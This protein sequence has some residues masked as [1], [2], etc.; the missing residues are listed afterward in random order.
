[1]P[2]N[3]LNYVNLNGSL[4]ALYRNDEFKDVVI[5][6]YIDKSNHSEACISFNDPKARIFFSY[7]PD[8]DRKKLWDY[9]MIGDTI[10]KIK[11]T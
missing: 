4:P 11:K 8:G 2:Y 9:V 7:R 1:V 10:R 3:N 6:K 5:N